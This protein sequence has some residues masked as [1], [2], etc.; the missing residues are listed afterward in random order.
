LRH[1]GVLERGVEVLLAVAIG[2]RGLDF[3]PKRQLRMAGLEGLALYVEDF[4]LRF[5]LET[6]WRN[7]RARGKLLEFLEACRIGAVILVVD[8]FQIRLDRVLLPC[9]I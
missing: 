5:D 2:E 1:G 3:H 6:L 9:R 4:R 8:F 7:R